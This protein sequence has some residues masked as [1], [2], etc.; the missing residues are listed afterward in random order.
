MVNSCKTK[1]AKENKKSRNLSIITTYFYIY[2]F[3]SLTDR[4]T[5][6]IFIIIDAHSSD[7]YLKLQTRKYFFLYF[8]IPAICSLDEDD[9]PTDKIFTE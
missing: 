5:D 7:L 4:H 9:R 2:F 1:I 6:K 3:S 8:Y